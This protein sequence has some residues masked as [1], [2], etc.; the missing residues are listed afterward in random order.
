MS[1]TITLEAIRFKCDSCTELIDLEE[2]PL[3]KGYQC[4]E[5]EEWLGDERRCD[6]CNKF[7]RKAT[8]CPECDWIIEDDPDGMMVPVITCV[9]H[10]E[11]HEVYN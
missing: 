9:C 2:M 3:S 7:G 10:D 8:A 1:I 4:P 5:C 11:E 6:Q